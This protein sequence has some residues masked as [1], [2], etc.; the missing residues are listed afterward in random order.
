MNY[1]G[2]G[3]SAAMMT[4][5]CRIT[6]RG[7]RS[8]RSD[9]DSSVHVQRWDGE[10]IQLHSCRIQRQDLTIE[11]Q[12]QSCF[13]GRRL[14]GTQ[15]GRLRWISDRQRLVRK[16]LLLFICT[17]WRAGVGYSLWH[18]L[19]FQAW[20]LLSQR[21]KWHNCLELSKVMIMKT[22]DIISINWTVNIMLHSTD[23]VGYPTLVL[24][25][26]PTDLSDQL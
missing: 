8:R 12:S 4:V 3:P 21:W 1:G 23:H 19:S 7:G 10:A 16:Q 25:N 26:L 20:W 24:E 6:G 13:C 11:E 9:P 2:H 22:W 14:G 15:V 18:R 17:H 5:G